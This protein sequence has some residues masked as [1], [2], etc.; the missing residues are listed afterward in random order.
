MPGSGK[1]MSGMSGID[2]L[3]DKLMSMSDITSIMGML[4]SNIKLTA[5]SV[6]SEVIISVPP[7][8]ASFPNNRSPCTDDD[9]GR[10][11]AVEVASPAL[12][13]ALRILVRSGEDTSRLCT[14]RPNLTLRPK[15]TEASVDPS[16]MIV[17]VRRASD[18]MV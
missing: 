3:R 7:S 6:T 10:V 18:A 2:M 5:S 17:V 8:A 16:R 4:C 9:D 14:D 1:M 15:M 13:P 11:T 12:A